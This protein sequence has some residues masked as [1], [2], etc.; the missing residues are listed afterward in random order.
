MYLIAPPFSVKWTGDYVP[1]DF[2][3]MVF[4]NPDFNIDVYDWH[5]VEEPFGE[6]QL[7]I[8]LRRGHLKR[9]GILLDAGE[10]SRLR[11]ITELTK[12]KARLDASNARMRESQGDFMEQLIPGWEEHGRKLD[13]EVDAGVKRTIDE[14]RAE[15]ESVLSEEPKPELVEYWRRSG[16]A[17]ID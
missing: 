7:Q 1:Q 10:L 13:A 2:K 5:P 12:S 4:E 6:P 17:F 11:Q 8:A 9:E 16:G 15:V 3:K 14:A